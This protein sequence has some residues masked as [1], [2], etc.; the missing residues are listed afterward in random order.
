MKT[1]HTKGP[2]IALKNSSFYEVY[3]EPRFDDESDR[4]LSVHVFLLDGANNGLHHTEENEA[5]A[6]LIAAAP[7]LLEA[8]IDLTEATKD[9]QTSNAPYYAHETKSDEFGKA[10]KAIKKATE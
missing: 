5:N 6:K 7:D 4:V 3:N 9:I 1:K 2:W 10:Y 8:L